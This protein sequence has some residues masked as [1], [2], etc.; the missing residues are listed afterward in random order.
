MEV[1]V[2]ENNI[3]RETEFDRMISNRQIDMLKTAIPFMPRNRQRILSMLVKLTEL[4]NTI[5]YY[6]QRDVSAME[7]CS[8]DAPSNALPELLEA[9]KVYCTEA[10][11]EQLDFIYQIYT[12]SVLM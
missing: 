11:R 9:L 12:A 7:A 1:S 4:K 2:G 10:E 3:R 8:S 5:R 6:D